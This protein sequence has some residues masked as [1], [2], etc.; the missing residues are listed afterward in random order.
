MNKYVLRDGGVC[1]SFVF[2][3]CVVIIEVSDLFIIYMFIIMFCRMWD[4]DVLLSR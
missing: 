3:K 2:S 4:E 1:L